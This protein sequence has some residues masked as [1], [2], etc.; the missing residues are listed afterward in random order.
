VEGDAGATYGLGY[1]DTVTT[2]SGEKKLRQRKGVWF[3]NELPVFGYEIHHGETRLGPSLSPLIRFDDGR[4]SD[5]AINASGR[6]WGTYLHGIFDSAD[7]LHDFLSLL[8]P[9]STSLTHF[10]AATDAAIL[11]EQAY[12]RL[13]STVL[14]SVNMGPILELARE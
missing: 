13:A 1:L 3:S 8:Q 10:D 6:I 11:R 2:L 7:F 12:D 4:E 9:E 14:E 5:G